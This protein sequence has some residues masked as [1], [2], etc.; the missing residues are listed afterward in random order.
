MPGPEVE[1]V[2]MTSADAE[3]VRKWLLSGEELLWVDRPWPEVEFTRRDVLLLLLLPVY[4]LI[5]WI[6]LDEAVESRSI[7]REGIGAVSD[8]T[9]GLIFAGCGLFVAFGFYA[10]ILRPMLDTWRRQTTI[11][12]LTD[13]RAIVLRPGAVRFLPLKLIHDVQIESRTPV[14]GTVR[15]RCELVDL[16]KFRIN[17]Q[18]TREKSFDGRLF[19]DIPD[20]GH[21]RTLM[22][23][24]RAALTGKR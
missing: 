3:T 16:L 24:A 20:P 13:E 18:F 22:I 14:R 5:A 21:V 4:V 6:V 9:L 15:C 19:R 10:A 7:Q 23:D 1:Q 8:A 17:G 12:G 11:Y 2:D